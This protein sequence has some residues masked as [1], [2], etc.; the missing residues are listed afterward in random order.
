MVEKPAGSRR[1]RAAGL[2]ATA[3]FAESGADQNE[4]DCQVLI[5]AGGSGR[6]K[7]EKGL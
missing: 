2:L 1:S 5:D 7:A 3:F 4:R 6:V